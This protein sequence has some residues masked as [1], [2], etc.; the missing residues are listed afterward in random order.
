MEIALG[1][2]GI[3]LAIL[4]LIPCGLEIYFWYFNKP[5]IQATVSNHSIQIV[6]T[7]TLDIQFWL[8]VKFTRGF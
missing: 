3:I 2:P 8:G 1:V 7:N 4:V 6:N 5:K